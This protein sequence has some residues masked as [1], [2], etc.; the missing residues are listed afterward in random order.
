MGEGRPVSKDTKAPG[1][2]RGWLAPSP[3]VGKKVGQLDCGWTK[4]A[5]GSHWSFSRKGVACAR[6]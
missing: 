6:W 1:V 5:M 3:M 2:W 4:W